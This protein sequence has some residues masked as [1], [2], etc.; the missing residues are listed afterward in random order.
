VTGEL[1]RLWELHG[2][3]EQAIV[4]RAALSKFE[5]ERVQLRSRLSS[6]KARVETVKQ[7]IADV[8]LRRRQIEKDAETAG[9]EEKKFQS[10][11]PNVKKNEEY[12]ALLHE[13]A[14][15]KQRRSDIETK[16]LELMEEEDA[17]QKEKPV[18]DKALADAEREVADRVAGVDREEGVKKGELEAIEARRRAALEGL[19]PQIRSRYE[20][21]HGSRDG[22]AVVAIQNGACGG[23]FRAQPPQALQDAR[24]G[25]RVLMCEGCGRMLILPPDPK[26][27]A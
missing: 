25:D 19:P 18:A 27:P 16:V 12:Q 2:L 7:R 22:R 20:R 23:C 8:Q 9:T 5:A 4:V 6:D 10:Q 15:V 17:A 11:L 13:I 26:A 21:I 14:A 1:E 24:R 3:D